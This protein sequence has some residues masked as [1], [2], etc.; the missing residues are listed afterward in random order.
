MKNLLIFFALA[1]I[2]DAFTTFYGTLSIFYSKYSL[3]LFEMMQMDYKKTLAAV[4]FAGVIVLLLLSA[5]AVLSGG[6]H[7]MF[8]VLVFVTFIY[9]AFTSYIG[10]Q[11]FIIQSS[12]MTIPQFFIIL[13]LTLVISGS[14]VAIPYL[15]AQE[16]K[17]KKSNH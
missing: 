15:L 2:W 9:D 1:S 4:G 17:Q 10:N 7:I 14:T 3:G 13:G 6:W 8:R 11:A 5:K 12:E 16:E